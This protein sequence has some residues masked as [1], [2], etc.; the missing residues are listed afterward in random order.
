[1][2]GPLN[3]KKEQGCADGVRTNTC[4]NKKHTTKEEEA[5]FSI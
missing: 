1:M 3:L 2:T 4:R 5:G